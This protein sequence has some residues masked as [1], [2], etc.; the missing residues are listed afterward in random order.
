MSASTGPDHGGIAEKNIP[1]D[2]QVLQDKDRM[3]DAQNAEKREHDMS[4]WEAAKNHPM[5][6]FWAFV[7]CF[8]IVSGPVV[9]RTQGCS[10][11]QPSRS[12]SRLTCS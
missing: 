12:W 4:L 3:T 8:T 1:A 6:C 9:R 2:T 10:N 5:A 11:T 7:I